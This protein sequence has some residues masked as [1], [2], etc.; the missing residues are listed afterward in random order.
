[1]DI[2]ASISEPERIALENGADLL[3]EQGHAAAQIIRRLVR[4]GK[5]PPIER[6]REGSGYGF[7]P[8][9]GYT[10]PYRSTINRPPWDNQ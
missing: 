2:F 6:P 9:A 8:P 10:P 3:E 1:M 7:S 5:P 4:P